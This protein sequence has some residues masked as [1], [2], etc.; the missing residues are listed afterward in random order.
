MGGKTTLDTYLE[1]MYLVLLVLFIIHLVGIDIVG[2][3]PLP[4]RIFHT[5]GTSSSLGSYLAIQELS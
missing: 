2:F 1:L 3:S 5:Y 4:V